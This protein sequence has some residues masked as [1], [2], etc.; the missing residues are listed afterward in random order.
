MGLFSGG[1]FLGDVGSFLGTN[2]EQQQAS[3][4]QAARVS[5]KRIR[6]GVEEIRGAGEFS[7]ASLL[8]FEQAGLGALPSVQQ[9]ATLE[10][11]AGNI[12][13][14]LGSGVLDPLVAERQRAATGALSQAGL[15]RSGQAARTAAEI[16]AELAFGIEDLLSGRQRDLVGIGQGAAGNLASL[17]QTDA[18]NIANL[19]A[20]A[21]AAQSAGILGQAQAKAAGQQNTLGLLSG[22]LSAA[23]DAGLLAG[24]GQVGSFLGALSDIRLKTN[25]RPIH[26][27][28]G[29]MLC[30]WDWL[31]GVE[32]LI[33][34]DMPMMNV[35]FIAQDVAELYP[36]YSGDYHGYKT[37]DYDG[38]LKEL[39]PCLH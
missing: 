26:N 27:V 37:I 17:R 39:E 34:D 14:I 1:G 19:L 4:G 24:L 18:A 5:E 31:P 8:P 28:G 23:G 38:L 3:I 36:E 32:E 12:S 16:P 22:G 2:T 20:E 25:I 29:L 7:Q 15:T 6:E 10:G 9:G 35:G 11:F 13:D 33:A 21:G 30:E